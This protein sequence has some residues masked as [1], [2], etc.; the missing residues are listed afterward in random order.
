MGIVKRSRHPMVQVIVRNYYTEEDKRIVTDQRI[1]DTQ[2]RTTGDDH[3]ALIDGTWVPAES[4]DP[5][6]RGGMH[7]EVYIG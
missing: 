1:L 7:Y 2:V 3:E 4:L 5:T 6:K